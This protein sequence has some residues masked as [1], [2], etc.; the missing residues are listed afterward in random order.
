MHFEPSF[1]YFNFPK[2]RKLWENG[3]SPSEKENKGVPNSWNGVFW[4]FNTSNKLVCIFCINFAA[5]ILEFVSKICLYK[6]LF[7]YYPI[8]KIYEQSFP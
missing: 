6:S 4:G 5:G 7:H 8:I 1:F 2:K 3:K